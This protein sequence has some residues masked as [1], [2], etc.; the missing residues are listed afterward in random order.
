MLA[1]GVDGSCIMLAIRMQLSGLFLAGGAGSR[2][3]IAD[4]ATDVANLAHLGDQGLYLL[5][6]QRVES[7]R[8]DRQ[9]RLR[10]SKSGSSIYPPGR[11]S[12]MEW[13]DAGH[14]TI[15]LSL[16]SCSRMVNHRRKGHSGHLCDLIGR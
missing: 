4:L 15:S 7:L 3:E 13:N 9:Y 6:Q 5:V 12:P 11:T 1:H 10:V 2:C 14:I 16:N 8:L